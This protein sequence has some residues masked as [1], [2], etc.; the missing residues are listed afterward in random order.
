MLKRGIFQQEKKGKSNFHGARLFANC[1]ELSKTWEEARKNVQHFR[2]K[3]REKKKN[4]GA[5][6]KKTPT[7]I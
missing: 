2:K 5:S 4:V 3:L 6:P 1:S 7:F